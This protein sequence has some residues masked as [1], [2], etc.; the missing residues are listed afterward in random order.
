MEGADSSVVYNVNDDDA[1]ETKR[2]IEEKRRKCFLIKTD[3]RSR[4]A[5]F[6]AVKENGKHF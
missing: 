5:C 3:V 6:K 1:Q 2:L 4:E